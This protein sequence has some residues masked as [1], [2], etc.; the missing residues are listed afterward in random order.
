M[1]GKKR[2]RYCLEC[3][4]RYMRE[5]RRY[6]PLTAEA[7]KHSNCRAYARVYLKR[8]KIKRRPCEVCGA[9]ET[10]MHHTDYDKPLVINWLCR[11]C[12]LNLHHGVE[13]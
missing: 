6:H 3:H 2:Q 8:G 13:S 9:R 11:E 12:H 4:A 1:P 10:E 5:W 7:R